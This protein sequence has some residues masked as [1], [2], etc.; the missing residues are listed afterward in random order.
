MSTMYFTAIWA[1]MSDRV[2]ARKV[3]AHL[4]TLTFLVG[5][6]FKPVQA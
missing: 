2:I 5:Q 1:L 3:A 4:S 6:A